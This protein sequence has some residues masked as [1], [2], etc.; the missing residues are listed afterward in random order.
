MSGTIRDMDTPPPPR[1]RHLDLD[2]QGPYE[3]GAT[4]PV[5]VRS[6][7]EQGR[8]IVQTSVWGE[9]HLNVG[10]FDDVDATLDLARCRELGVE[11]IRRPMYGGGT[12]YYGAECAAMWGLLLP[13]G[14]VSLDEQLRRFQPVVSDALDRIG[15]G[16]VTF[17]GSSDLRWKDRKLGALT[18]QDVMVCDAVGGFLNLQRPDLDLYLS[19]VRIPDEKFKDKAV[20]DMREYVCTAEEVAGRPV[21]YEEFRDA[22]VAA[23]VDAGIELEHSALT[24]GEMKGFNKISARIGTDEAIRRI[25]SER[26]RTDA[27]VGSRVGL[28][29]EKGRKLCRAGVAIDDSGVIVAAMMAGDMH[30]SPPDTMDRVAAALVGADAA[31]DDDLR[32]RIAGVF[33]GDEVHQADQMMG[34][35][36]DDLLAATRKAIADAG[37]S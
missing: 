23:L 6:V 14:E 2:R 16:A 31:D 13:K 35:T 5:L 19:V 20:K 10:W 15:L 4:M 11:V 36:T 37:L 29:N 28:G 18:A 25:S 21:S 12:A 3:N 17:E 30:V 24:E 9:T 32:A 33:D 8:P 27:P 26:F 34:V 22:M 1:W 7:A